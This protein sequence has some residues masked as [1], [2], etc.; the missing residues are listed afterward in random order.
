MGVQKDIKRYIFKE[1]WKEHKYDEVP[2]IPIVYRIR[3]QSDL[4]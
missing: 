4:S 1:N 3:P 2:V